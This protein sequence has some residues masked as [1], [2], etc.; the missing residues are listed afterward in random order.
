M[1]EKTNASSDQKKPER[2]KI[3]KRVNLADLPKVFKEALG[4]SSEIKSMSDVV[5]K[6]LFIQ[7]RLQNTILGGEQE[8]PQRW[9]IPRI[10][11]EKRNT[12]IILLS[13][14]WLK[15]RTILDMVNAREKKEGRGILK[16]TRAINKI[17]EKFS[18]KPRSIYYEN[19]EEKMLIEAWI[20]K[21]QEVV[22]KCLLALQDEP[23]DKKSIRKRA[24]VQFKF[25][26][27][28]QMYI[29]TQWWN[30]SR[31]YKSSQK[32]EKDEDEYEEID[33]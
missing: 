8:E 27:I 14:A 24:E 3:P 12:R 21:Q 1:T 30:R 11:L 26:Q 13:R 25:I 23:N 18:L 28:Q 22:E 10:L 4:I 5:E 31:Y 7:E 20:N 33:E 15:T 17:R 16:N 9:Y 6:D 32:K 2:R 19:E 29:N